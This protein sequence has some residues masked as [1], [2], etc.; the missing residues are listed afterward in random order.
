M[1]TCLLVAVLS[2]SG[3]AASLGGLPIEDPRTYS[4]PSGSFVH[5]DDEVIVS[6]EDVRSE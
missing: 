3:L 4:S 2:G 5:P 1:F 6:G